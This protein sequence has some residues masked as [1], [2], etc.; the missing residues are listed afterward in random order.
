MAIFEKLADL[1]PGNEKLEDE[2]KAFGL[3]GQC[4][5]LT[6]RHEYAESN[7]VMGQL[8]PI[9][10][11]LTSERMKKLV[12]LAIEE[13]PLQSGAAVPAGVGQVVRGPVRRRGLTAGGG[14][15]RN[16]SSIGCRPIVK[17]TTGPLRL[18]A[19]DIGFS[20][21]EQGFDSPRGYYDTVVQ[22]RKDSQRIGKKPLFSGAFCVSCESAAISCGRLLHRILRRY[23]TGFC[24]AFCR[25]L[26]VGIRH[27]DIG[28]AVIGAELRI[29][30]VRYLLARQLGNC[31]GVASDPYETRS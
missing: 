9:Y 8:A 25:P 13:E 2:L 15:G 18:V 16:C 11:K 19:Q 12:R 30:V 26:K 20:V 27:V 29:Q 7:S 1:N 24:S 28:R 22:Y 17:R 4:V 23:C 6:I 5:V 21:R 10:D 3:A 31:M 14:G